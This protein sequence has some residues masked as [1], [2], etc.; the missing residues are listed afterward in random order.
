MIDIFLNGESKKLETTTTLSSV[1]EQWGYNRETIA[2]ALNETFIPRNL[3]DS[4][5]I[6]N[7]DCVEVVSAMQGG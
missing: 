4:T 6:R 5:Q 2:T 7:G 1:L 3:Y